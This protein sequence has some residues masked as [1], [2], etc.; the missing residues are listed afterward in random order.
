M[1]DYELTIV[2][3]KYYRDKACGIANCNCDKCAAS[4]YY[5]FKTLCCFDVVI[6]SIKHT[7]KQEIEND[8]G[9]SSKCRWYL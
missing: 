4:Y 1:E 5:C 6:S 2:A 9:C 8:K 3:I 7:N